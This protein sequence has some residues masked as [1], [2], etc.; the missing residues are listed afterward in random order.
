M[1]RVRNRLTAA[2]F[3]FAYSVGELVGAHLSSLLR[4]GIGIFMV[5]AA[6]I[7]VFDTLKNPRGKC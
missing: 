6:T 1:G 2:W 4:C 3:I 7:I 5:L